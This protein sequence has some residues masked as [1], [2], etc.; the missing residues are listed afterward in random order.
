MQRLFF[1][2]LFISINLFAQIDTSDYYPLHVGDKWIYNNTFGPGSYI[3]KVIGDTLMPNGYKY[4]HLTFIDNE[5]Q[6][7]ENN[8]YVKVYNEYVESSEYQRVENN[9]DVKIYNEYVENSEY[10]RFDLFSVKGTIFS[11]SDTISYGYGIY[12]IGIDN[13]NLID[14]RLEW[15]EFRTVLVDTTVVPPD[16]TWYL[17]V[18]TYAK[19]VTKGIGV[20]AYHFGAEV[21]IGALINSVGYG[22]LS[23]IEADTKEIP[24]NFEL[25]QNYPNPFNP[26][27]KIAFQLPEDSK[28]AI[29]IYNVLGQLVYTLLEEN[30]SA[31]SYEKEFNASSLQSGVYFY[32]LETDNFSDVKKMVLLY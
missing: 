30:M 1:I 31:G 16:T 25:S 19:R 15:R 18:D 7:A 2:Y 8:R 12:D 32:R 14:K 17:A 5:Y 11:P 24:G 10:T 9:R 27:T 13:N 4:F 28:V 23:G 3:V 29:R 6:R 20:T 21:L 26:T 22:N